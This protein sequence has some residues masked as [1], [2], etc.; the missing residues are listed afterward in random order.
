MINS[1]KILVCFCIASY[2]TLI[3][4][5][6]LCSQRADSPG[7]DPRTLNGA[8]KSKNTFL[9]FFFHSVIRGM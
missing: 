3:A 2:L 1:G 5:C 8:T 7:N 6:I 4:F 9:G